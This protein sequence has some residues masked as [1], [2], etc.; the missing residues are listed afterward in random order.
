MKFSYFQPLCYVS[1]FMKQ[2]HEFFQ[3][4][5]TLGP[6]NVSGADLDDLDGGTK[7]TRA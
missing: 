7:R 3:A 6:A 5:K 1:K 2:S 4:Y